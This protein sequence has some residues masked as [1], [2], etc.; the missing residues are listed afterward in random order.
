MA[1]SDHAIHQDLT[2]SPQTEGDERLRAGTV[3]AQ[4]AAPDLRYGVAGDSKL[5]WINFCIWPDRREFVE[6]VGHAELAERK[7]HLP[8]V[9]GYGSLCYL[10]HPFTDREWGD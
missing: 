3:I 8:S 9:S 6:I 2:L 5:S 1:V 10:R 7:P 4:N